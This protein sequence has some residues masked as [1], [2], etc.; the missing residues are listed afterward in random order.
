MSF[1]KGAIMCCFAI[2]AAAPMF[3]D[4]V[5]NGS[6]GNGFITPVTPTATGQS[7]AN[8]TNPNK[9][10]GTAYWDN[11]SL[12]GTT[13]L[14]CNIGFIVTKSPTITSCSNINPGGTGLGV[15]DPAA[16]AYWGN[17]GPGT[18]TGNYDPSFTISASN[19]PATAEFEISFAGYQT[20]DTFGYYDVTTAG[21]LVPLFTAG[22]ATDTTALVTIPVGDQIGFYLTNLVGTTFRSTDGGV[23]HF[24]LFQADNRNFYI[25]AEDGGATGIGGG[26]LSPTDYDYNDVVAHISQVPEPGTLP[27]LVTGLMGMALIVRRRMTAKK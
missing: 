24:A 14:G 10:N 4:L 27:V 5:V 16:T 1:S 26:G 12:D 9:N 23:Q 18:S 25:G 20:G 6:A 13:G 19:Q 11:Q 15:D 3:A 2:F 8:I 21:P 22:I 7:A 17:L